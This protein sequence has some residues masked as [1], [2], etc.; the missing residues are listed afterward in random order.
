MIDETLLADPGRCPA[1]AAILRSPA[2]ECPA[3]H[4]SLRGPTAG[5][6]WDVSREV[7]RLLG[8]RTRLIAVLRAEA[9]I[10]AYV[11]TAPAPELP[12]PPRPATASRPVATPPRAEW[13]PQRVQNLLLALGV[14]LLGVAAV[15][16]VAV[17]WG[18]LGV[19]G[20]AAVLT[21]V[22]ALSFAAGTVAHRRGLTATA[23][24]LSLLTVGLALLDCGGARAANLFDL[25]DV[26]GL[27]VAAGSAALVASL[28]AAGAVTLPTRALRLSA[29]VLGQLPAPLLAVHLADT[30]RHPAALLAAATTAQALLGLAVAVWWPGRGD[31]RDAR[32]VVGVGAV[33]AAVVATALA[34]GAAYG[35][36][37][38]LVVGSVL[39]LVL[40]AGAAAAAEV[41]GVR[42]VADRAP[43]FLR[44]A[45][46][47][48]V[49]ASAWAPVDDA[50]GGRWLPLA[51][52]ATAAALLAATALVPLDRRVAPVAVTLVATML[53][54]ASSLGDLLPAAAGRVQWLTGAWS[55]DSGSAR[56]LLDAHRSQRHGPDRVAVD[57]S[58]LPARR[59][60]PRR[61]AP[62][63]PAGARSSAGT[64]AGR[65]GRV[66]DAGLPGCELPRRT[67]VRPR[68]RH[69]PR[70]RGDVRPRAPRRHP[71]GDRDGVGR[72]GRRI[73][74]AGHG[75]GLVAGRRRRD[76]R[77]AAGRSGDPLGRRGAVDAGGTAEV[78]GDGGRRGGRSPPR[79][80]E[81]RRHPLRRGRL[82]GRLVGRPGST[83][84]AC[85]GGVRSGL[86]ALARHGLLDGDP[87]GARR[88]RGGRS[89]R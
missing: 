69:R 78:G 43:T 33:A 86:A 72:P 66:A 30:S 71:R 57:R 58:A 48:L 5:R 81:R 21:G 77:R 59:G 61:S 50:V 8:E 46:A 11:A 7:A 73:R 10:P 85:H 29:A 4:L 47:A 44:G 17:S 51:L 62:A 88:R 13:T 83:G 24:A 87:S 32:V 74:R 31:S 15:I 6:L 64:P 70:A 34:L 14:V 82:A 2:T 84:R 12:P 68:P 22:T 89:R 9:T 45:A 63:A 35:E 23:E 54:S 76:S 41:G 19:G 80:R 42:R 60:R 18:R 75:R 49:V 56:R 36:E 53:P 67:G 79:R 65:G 52:A 40:A 25:R 38:S 37:G 3:C 27:V 26:D 20:R 28:A 16:F 39:L 1:C 55:A